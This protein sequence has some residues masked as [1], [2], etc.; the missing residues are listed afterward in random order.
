[1]TVI[2]SATLEKMKNARKRI[3]HTVYAAGEENFLFK[4]LY[5]GRAERQ[6]KSAHIPEK[7]LPLPSLC[8]RGKY[9]SVA[10]AGGS[11]EK[12]KPSI[13]KTSGA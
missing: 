3:S 9:S 1:M 10:A 13:P 12:R 11:T 8:Q 7:E 5:I 2:S 4:Y 6:R